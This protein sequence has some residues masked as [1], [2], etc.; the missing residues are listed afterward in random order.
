MRKIIEYLEKLDFSKNE[1]K[2]YITLLK[3]GSL[4]V[5]ELAQKAK[6]NRTATYGYVNLLT[7]KGVIAKSKG[8]SNK[9]LANPPEHLHYLVDERLSSAKKLQEELYPVVTTLNANFMKSAMT[10]NSE[11]KYFKGRTGIRA[12]YDDCLKANKIRSYFNPKETINLLPENLGLFE[13]IIAKRPGMEIY[14]LAEDSVE[15]RERARKIFPCPRLYWKFL[16][17]DVKL[18]SNDI[19][20]Y[21]GKVAIVNLIDED[22]LSGFILRNQD[23]Y[24]NSVQLFDLLWRLLPNNSPVLKT[25]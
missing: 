15:S 24:N 6:F 18:T 9:V 16:P 10:N 22:T 14:E 3:N 7:E 13:R 4:T 1:A 5:S 17:K 19:L 20:I 23:Y 2:I 12:I 21:D 8:E 11:M 25:T